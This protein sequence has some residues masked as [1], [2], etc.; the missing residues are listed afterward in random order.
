MKQNKELLEPSKLYQDFSFDPENIYEAA[1]FPACIA[2]WPY[3][4][5]AL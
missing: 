5:L 3:E 2:A 4:P 1:L